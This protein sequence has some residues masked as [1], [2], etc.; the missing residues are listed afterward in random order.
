MFVKHNE[1]DLSRHQWLLQLVEDADACLLFHVVVGEYVVLRGK[2]QFIR[3]VH[4]KAELHARLFYF[5]RPFLVQEKLVLCFV[6]SV[7]EDLCYDHL[8]SQLPDSNADAHSQLV[9]RD[10]N[11]ADLPVLR[12][13]LLKVAQMLPILSFA[14]GTYPVRRF[15]SI[16]VLN[17]ELMT[18]ADHVLL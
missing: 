12:A 14:V 8:A 2:N 9:G 7:Y 15:D 5:E 13:S 10:S 4:A 6:A 18:M 17:G 11:V 3:V 16:N 1:S